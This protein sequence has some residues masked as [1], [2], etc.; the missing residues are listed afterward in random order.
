EN[1]R[2][3]LAAT[4]LPYPAWSRPPEE[5]SG[6]ERAR[7]GLA[8]AMAQPCDILLLDEPDNDLDLAAVEALESGLDAKLKDTGAALVIA[9]HDRRLA[10]AVADRVWTIE[11]GALVAH[12][13]VA[14]YLRGETAVP[15]A[16]FWQ[17]ARPYPVAQ[18][19]RTDQ[20]VADQLDLEAERD[21]ILDQLSDPL[22]LGDREQQ[23]L[24]HRLRDVESALMGAYEATLTPAAPRHRLVE[25]GLTVYADL[26]CSADEDRAAGTG[27]DVVDKLLLVAAADAQEAAALLVAGQ[28]ATAEA[29]LEAPWLDIRLVDDLAHMRLGSLPGA[30]LLPTTAH[31]LIDA[32]TRLAFT[33]MGAGRVQIFSHDDLGSTM[34][35]HVRDS[36]WGVTLARF[37]TVEGWSPAEGAAVSTRAAGRARPGRRRRRKVVSR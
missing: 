5:L 6:G 35:A 29:P 13:S 28:T 12:G 26:L 36:W 9:T 24:R 21:T 16:S 7:V 14:A 15:A 8:L 23:R 33:V 3:V 20:A 22:A 4:G 34:L 19:P 27:H 17:D 2:N 25:R 37:L 18:E 32:G 31:A 1:A 11:A 10:R 30:C